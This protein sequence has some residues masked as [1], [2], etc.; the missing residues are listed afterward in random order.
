MRLIAIR[1][2]LGQSAA[3]GDLDLFHRSFTG[4]NSTQLATPQLDGTDARELSS[5]LPQPDA[6]Q[7]E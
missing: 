1:W 5:Q 4:L 6:T 2:P 7:A 3:G